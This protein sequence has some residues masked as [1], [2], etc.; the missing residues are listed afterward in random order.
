MIKEFK[1][2]IAQGNVLEMAVGIIIGTAFKAVIDSLVADIIT[3]ILN[4]F[5]KGVD[6]KDLVLQVGPVNF[7]IGNFINTIVSFLIIGFVMFLIVKG[8][9]KMRKEKPVDPTTKICPHCQT[10]IPV[11]ATRC[12]HCTSEL[13][14]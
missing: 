9:N 10:E 11:N 3:P 6:F 1:D 12:P 7:A 4:V 5:L 8:F 2:F 14:K 13:T